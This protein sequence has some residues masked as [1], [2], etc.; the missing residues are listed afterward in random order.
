MGTA[1]T[2]FETVLKN[3]QK[4]EKQFKKKVT[5][6]AFNKALEPIKQQAQINCRHESLKKLIGKKVITVKKGSRKGE[7]S[8][9]VFMKPSKDRKIIL[10]KREVG[11]EVVANILEFGRKKGDLK[12]QPFMRP[13]IAMRQQ[14]AMS[15]LESEMKKGLKRL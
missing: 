3:I 8:G 14:E 9:K 13:A 11:F 2:G 15:I 10:D 7:I 6:P 12:P 1:V 5:K 4:V